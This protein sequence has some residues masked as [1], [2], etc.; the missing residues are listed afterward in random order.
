MNKLS[1]LL[2]LTV[3][4]ASA[5]GPAEEDAPVTE[6]DETS[7][8]TAI[9]ILAT[10]AARADIR[11]AAVAR[12][13]LARSIDAPAEIVLDPDR[14]AHL[15]PLVEAKIEKVL[16]RLGDPVRAGSVLAVLRSLAVGESRANLSQ[17]G[18][19]LELAQASLKR[20][21]ELRAS[22]I[23]AV[24]DY[25]A[26]LAST[27]RAEAAMKAARERSAIV[28]SYELR[29]PIAGTVIER[30][31]TIGETV[32]PDSVLFTVADL[33]EVWVVGQVYERDV[34]GVA[35]GTVAKLSLAAFPGKE[36]SGTLS[37][38]AGAV[39]HETRTLPVRMV[40]SN[41]DGALRPGLFGSLAI[42][43]SDAIDV[44]A[45]PADAVQRVDARS[46][47]FVSAP[48]T[49]DKHV[50]FTAREVTLGRNADDLVEVKAGLKAGDTIAIAGSFTLR[51][52]M[53]R[54]TLAEED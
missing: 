13:H 12:Q 28:G 22:N 10:A 2:T 37:Y 45:I 17:S 27:R 9:T 32:G 6:P 26:A 33:A 24:R 36:W 48:S 44:L 11:V 39:E 21:E 3:L 23:G 20:Q 19:D 50:S 30:H 14:T 25:E 31:A 18:A 1:S 5:C 8:P 7:A 47:V 16:V 49:D 15:G 29:A 35:H 54:D 38:V 40:L 4:L 42:E 51:S 43:A 52:E 34:G 46:I 41:A 53:L